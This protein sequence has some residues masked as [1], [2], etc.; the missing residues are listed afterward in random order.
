[1]RC[2]CQQALQNGMMHIYIRGEEKKGGGKARRE[3]KKN[4]LRH[5]GR[6]D[7]HRHARR[8]DEPVPARKLHRRDDA[9]AADGHGREQKR[10]HA[11]EHRAGDGDQRGGELCEDAHDEQPEAGGVPGVAV[12]AAGERD[13]AV[14][15]REDGHG[16][17]GAEG[18]DYA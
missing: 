3:R 13:D 16:G 17:Y 1:M 12:C 5:H 15:L 8:Q 10:R 14:V 6:P 2:A 7:P 11:A 9:D 4:S 18:G